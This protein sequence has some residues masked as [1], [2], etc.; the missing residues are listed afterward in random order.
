MVYDQMEIK[1][2]S[3]QVFGIKVESYGSLLILVVMEKIFEEFW[4]VISCKMKLDVWDVNELIEVFK[5]ELEVCE[6]S[7]FV[8]G[9]GNV[10]EKFWLKFK[11]FCDF[12]IV[13]VLFLLE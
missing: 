5:E 2:C 4:F 6:K 1:I 13:V 12:I 9:F 3:L 10:V 7:R 8:G 11:I